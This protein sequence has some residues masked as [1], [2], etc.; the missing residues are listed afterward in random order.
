MP[1]G[2]VI[3]ALAGSGERMDQ[4][5]VWTLRMP[6]VLLA[7]LAGAALALAGLLLQ[8]VMRNPIASPS[9]LGLVDGAAVGVVLY[10]WNYS[11]E[12]HA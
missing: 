6:R 3:A 8:R 11:N 7:M 1:L 4:V 5:I 2:R 10:F 9:V 12:A